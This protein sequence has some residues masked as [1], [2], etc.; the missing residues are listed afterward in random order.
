VTALLKNVG[1]SCGLLLSSAEECLGR[2]YCSNL[3]WFENNVKI[4][5]PLIDNKNEA[6]QKWL[7]RDQIPE[8]FLSL[9]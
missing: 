6:L 8:G 2:G 5:K 4:L 3:E 1:I 7:Q 9:M